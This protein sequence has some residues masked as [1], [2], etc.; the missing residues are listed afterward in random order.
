M[1]LLINCPLSLH[2]IMSW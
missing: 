2:K 1:L